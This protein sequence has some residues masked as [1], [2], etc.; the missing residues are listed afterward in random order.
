MS[1]QATLSQMVNWL[2]MVVKYPANLVSC[3]GNDWST[4]WQY[5]EI[6]EKKKIEGVE[7]AV[8]H[9]RACVCSALLM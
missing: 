8:M 9:F 5:A 2:T 4:S 6:R 7:R 1:R 3:A